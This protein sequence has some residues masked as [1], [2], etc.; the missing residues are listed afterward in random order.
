VKYI[1]T[2]GHN[3]PLGDVVRLGRFSRL[4]KARELI[5]AVK[6][7]ADEADKGTGQEFRISLVAEE[8][9]VVNKQKERAA[10]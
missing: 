7:I 10:K 3:V 9:H 2:I 8:T 1:I 4:G 5:A 6:A